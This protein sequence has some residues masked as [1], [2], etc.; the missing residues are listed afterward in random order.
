VKAAAKHLVHIIEE[1][2]TFSRVE[3]GKEPLLPEMADGAAIA[4]AVVE[5]FEPQAGSKHL[6]MQIEIP[7]AP[8]MLFTDTTKLRQILINIVGNAMKFTETGEVDI[9]VESRAD[10]VY[11]V[12]RDTGPGMTAED[13]ER[14]FDPFTQLDQSL[15]RSKGGTGLGLPV[16]RKLAHLLGGDLVVTSVPGEGTTFTL[17]LPV[18]LA[19]EPAIPPSVIGEPVMG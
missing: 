16:S 12:V 11:F 19:P 9:A 2:L 17:C 13:L 14:I 6:R 1:I 15:S 10:R 7:P 8:V 5:L 18:A 4:N 3:A